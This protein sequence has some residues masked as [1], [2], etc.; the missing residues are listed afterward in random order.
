[1]SNKIER[2]K[3]T[4]LIIGFCAISLVAFYYFL[5]WN[6]SPANRDSITP[7]N[8]DIQNSVCTQKVDALTI[9][10]DITPKPV[11]TMTPLSFRVKV[12]GEF[13]E[14]TV[15]LDLSMPGMKMGPNVVRLKNT[16]PNVFEGRGVIVKCPSGKSIWQASVVLADSKSID[17]IFDV[18]N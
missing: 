12:L 10:L 2:A 15:L 7:P 1:M 14:K 11:K 16:A 13:S 8:C 3:A 9:L 4:L 6:T 18:I 5:Y 17:F